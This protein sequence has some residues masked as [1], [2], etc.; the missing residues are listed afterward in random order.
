MTPRRAQRRP[1]EA[2]P[3]RTDAVPVVETGPD[4]DW[5]VRA[6]SGAAAAKTYRCPGCEQ[7]IG[8]GTPHV[9]A[10]RRGEEDHRRHWHQPCWRA[11]DRRR[12]RG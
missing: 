10:W 7:E 1:D 3:L 11:R 9:V 8:I 6:V 2:R 5:F 12:P 4:G